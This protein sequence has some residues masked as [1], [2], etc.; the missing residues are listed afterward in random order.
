[1]KLYALIFILCA[2]YVSSGQCA[3]PTNNPECQ[4]L[5]DLINNLKQ[6]FDRI[7][8]SLIPIP[9]LD[10]TKPN[11]L[12]CYE[13]SNCTGFNCSGKVYG[14][15]IQ[16]SFDMSYCAKPIT[17]YISANY[18]SENITFSQKIRHAEEF[19]LT[20]FT[21]N[22]PNTN[23]TVPVKL[24]G[25]INMVRSPGKVTVTAGI[26]PKFNLLFPIPLQS[27]NLVNNQVIR[28]NTAVCGVSKLTTA[29]HADCEQELSYHLPSHFNLDEVATT[30]STSGH[31]SSSPYSGMS[32][33]QGTSTK[34]AIG[35]G[36][37]TGGAI[38]AIVTS[39][40]AIVV[41]FIVGVLL[42]FKRSKRNNGYPLTE[43][44]EK[45]NVTM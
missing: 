40:V 25:K 2:F 44:K 18:P 5:S 22:V 37:L 45:E 19:Y 16:F 43:E 7:P 8:L 38:A 1:M 20:Q 14:R 9:G 36:G 4:S 35:S 12:K 21:F 26:V 30:S 24:Y 33:M 42:H 23:I 27:F 29:N 17:A 28:V 3:T 10:P 32:T 15:Q 13:F 39:A 31:G 41:V 11:T 6:N 34:Q